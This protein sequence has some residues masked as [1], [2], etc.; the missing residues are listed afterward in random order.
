MNLFSKNMNRQS[1]VMVLSV[2]LV[3]AIGYALFRNLAIRADVVANSGSLR[4]IVN[5]DLGIPLES[6]KVSITSDQ[7]NKTTV[8]TEKNSDG[9]YQAAIGVGT[10]TIEAESQGY[11]TDSQPT[12]IEAG[13]I[14]EISFYLHQP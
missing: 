11:A 2:F 8:L 6:A 4:V 1:A 3:I 14:Q 7:T 5:D 9:S 10:F 12:A 13:Q